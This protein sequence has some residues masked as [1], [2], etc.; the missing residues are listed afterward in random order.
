MVKTKEEL[1]EVHQ[2]LH[3]SLDNLVGCYIMNVKD[4]KSLTEL[5]VMELIE[6]SHKQ[7]K[8]PSCYLN[9][10]VTR[11]FTLVLKPELI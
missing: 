4:R 9:Q 1:Q 6:W 11:D 2:D 7:C 5:S 3:R 10:I 8:N